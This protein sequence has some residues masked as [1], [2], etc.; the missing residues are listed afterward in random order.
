MHFGQK[1]GLWAKYALPRFNRH[2]DLTDKTLSPEGTVK[3]GSDC[4]A[5][6]PARLGE[7]DGHLCACQRSD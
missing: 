6:W 5:L 1:Q 4:T 3:S 2:P 7:G